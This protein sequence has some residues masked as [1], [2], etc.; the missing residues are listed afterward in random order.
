MHLCISRLWLGSAPEVP[1]YLE[2]GWYFSTFC[3]IRNK[4]QQKSCLEIP[5]PVF[6][7]Y[8]HVI[9][10]YESWTGLKNCGYIREVLAE[11]QNFLMLVPTQLYHFVFLQAF[12]QVKL[13]DHI[14]LHGKW[15]SKLFCVH[16]S[17]FILKL[18][19]ILVE[20]YCSIHPLSNWLYVS[21]FF[22]NGTKSN[23]SLNTNLD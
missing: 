18:K 10:L 14:S 9:P 7:I 11:F 13:N 2:N 4:N 8:I 15:V 23:V 21:L 22:C 20:F 3:L 17:R 6:Q 12:M 16:Q 19:Q 1:K 5:N